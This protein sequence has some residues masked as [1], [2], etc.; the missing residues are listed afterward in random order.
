MLFLALIAIIISRADHKCNFYSGHYGE[1]LCE[2]ILNLDQ[3]LRFCIKVLSISNSGDHFFQQS[4]T[5]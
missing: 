5:V 4:K 3:W 2:L 1:H